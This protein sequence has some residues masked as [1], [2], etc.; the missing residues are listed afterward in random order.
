MDLYV[1]ALMKVLIR[2]GVPDRKGPNGVRALSETLCW[3]GERNLYMATTERP[4]KRKL[5]EAGKSVL[6][7]WWRAMEIR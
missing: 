2:A 3:M 6:E 4:G 1:D 5:K 7:I